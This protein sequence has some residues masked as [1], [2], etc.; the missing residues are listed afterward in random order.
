MNISVEIRTIMEEAIENAKELHAEKVT[1]E[2]YEL[3]FLGYE[4]VKEAFEEVVGK[5]ATA[6]LLKEVEQKCVNAKKINASVITSAEDKGIKLSDPIPSEISRIAFNTAN[7]IAK[8]RKR[9]YVDVDDLFLAI[10]NAN[11]KD[12]NGEGC[13]NEFFDHDASMIK[14]VTEIL[15]EPELSPLTMGGEESS[16]FNWKEY[17]ENLIEKAKTFDKPFVGREDL[18]EATI[19]VLARKE[20]CNPVHVGEPGVGKTAITYGL[21]KRILDGKVPDKLKK[22]TLYSIDLS[23]MLAGCMYRGM[24]EERLKIVLKEISK[25]EMPIMFIDE[26]HMIVGAGATGNDSMDASNILKPYLTEGKIRIIGA[27]TYEEYKKYIEKDKALAR[28][29]QRIV[30]NEPS[31]E[32]TIKIIKGLK[33]AYEEFHEVVYTDEA[34]ETAVK[35]SD[36]YIKDRFLPDKAIDLIDEAGAEHT[37]H[38][39]KSKKITKSMIEKLIQKNYKV[40]RVEAEKNDISTLRTMDTELKKVVFGQAEAIKEIV[41]AI[42]LSK[43]GLGDTEKPIGSFLFVGPSGVGKTELAKQLANLLNI[44]FIRFDMSEYQDKTTVNKLI[45]A[46]AGYVGYEDSGLLTE[47]V[48]KSPHS[49][50]LF[51]EIEKAHQDVYKTFLQVMDYGMLTD[52]QGRKADFRNAIIIFTSN[53]GA[54]EATKAKLGFGN[55]G[56]EMNNAGIDN[57]LK[58][59]FTPEFRNRLTKVIT[60]NAI[61]E[62]IGRMVVIKELK[63]LTELLS[64]KK[65][66]VTYTDNVI[67]QIIK[68]GVSRE[69]GARGIQRTINENI[70]TLFVDAIINEETLNNVVVD[71]DG[72]FKLDDKSKEKVVN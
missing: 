72:N 4:F 11:A 35:L 48:R 66:T 29:F 44:D 13:L 34:I 22:A 59:T 27:T 64:K 30:V 3:N 20:K 24:F 23:G 45:G 39:G 36:K 57:A 6:D 9:D 65:I 10:V 49:V 15:N 5:E 52:N 68:M 67:N 56:V 60:F 71:Y 7:A 50:I 62:K 46:S 70:K 43:T 58:E 32:D 37:L 14:S 31:I 38:P 54:N 1:L 26:I 25:D 16:N 41:N 2:F 12:L 19:R 18:I 21:A 63:K 51:D 61:D 69:F 40:V 53:A 55:S 8:K 47:S 17:A 33:E 42:K 28:R